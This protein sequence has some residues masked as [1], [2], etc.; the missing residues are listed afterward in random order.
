MH[1]CVDS[2]DHKSY[3]Q[4][5]HLF[6]SFARSADDCMV[7]VAQDDKT[8]LHLAS[9]GGHLETVSL[10]L[11][12]GAD[13]HAKDTVSLSLDSCNRRLLLV[14]PMSAPY[15]VYLGLFPCL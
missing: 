1:H 5:H 10:L 13:I 12:W 15:Y 14:M 2:H 9:D 6:F 7:N 3:T 4:F 11:K 8:A